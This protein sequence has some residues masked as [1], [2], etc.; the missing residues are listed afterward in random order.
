VAHPQ[1]AIGGQGQQPRSGAA[2]IAYGGRADVIGR[3][4]GQYIDQAGFGRRAGRHRRPDRL[5][6]LAGQPRQHLRRAVRVC[7]DQAPDAVLL[8]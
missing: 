8:I 3:V 4:A 5:L 2:R 1:A 7:R 6:L